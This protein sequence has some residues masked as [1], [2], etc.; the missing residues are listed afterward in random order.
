MTKKTV[1]KTKR[2]PFDLDEF[3]DDKDGLLEAAF[4]FAPD[5]ASDDGMPE[6]PADDP[7]H[8]AWPNRERDRSDVVQEMIAQRRRPRGR[9]VDYQDDEA[10][11]DNK[12]VRGPYPY[13]TVDAA[14]L[15]TCLSECTQVLAE[16][17]VQGAKIIAG[18][19]EVPAAPKHLN[20]PVL[21]V[22]NGLAEVREDTLIET[23]RMAGYTVTKVGCS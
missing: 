7:L 18:K 20:V 5:R 19:A 21:D 11:N 1:R 13:Q 12:S 15:R 2:K 14:K 16:A 3:F 10:G 22:R 8:G 23:L 6:V 4:P 9:S 17:I